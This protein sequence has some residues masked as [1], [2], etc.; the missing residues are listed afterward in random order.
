MEDVVPAAGAAPAAP[1]AAPP[2]V[3]WK[4]LQK[5]QHTAWHTER[6]VASAVLGTVVAA[7]V[8]VGASI[9]GTL[10]DTELDALITLAI[11][12]VAERYAELLAAGVGDE[13]LTPKR[14][15]A[16]LGR[17]WPMLEAAL[18]PALVLLFVALATGRLQ[19]GT[20]A[21]LGVATVLL[22]Y[23]GRLAARRA[24]RLGL[25]PALA[26]AGTAALLGGVVIVL[27]FS[28]H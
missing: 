11:Y 21:A 28:L 20:L 8:M 13:P 7:S 14:L 16:E 10:F 26:W 25:A 23:L 18:L 22:G 9:H 3:W 2:V 4:R 5:W 24:G 15:A 1:P 6:E 27:K 17:G 19:A 12:W